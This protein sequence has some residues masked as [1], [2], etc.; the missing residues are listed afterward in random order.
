MRDLGES[1]VFLCCVGR[2]MRATYNDTKNPPAFT[3]LASTLH[4]VRKKTWAQWCKTRHAETNPVCGGVTNRAKF[5]M[6]LSEG[7]FAE[8]FQEETTFTSKA[9]QD[10]FHFWCQTC[11]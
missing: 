10:D 1:G 11:E 7:H 2:L 9:T 3:V 8:H 5:V 6:A 4:Q